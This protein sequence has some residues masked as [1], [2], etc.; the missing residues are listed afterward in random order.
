MS[1]A[2]IVLL[3][4]HLYTPTRRGRGRKGR[5]AGSRRRGSPH[6]LERT[7]QS[8]GVGGYARRGRVLAAARGLAQQD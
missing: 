2:A 6:T 5:G 8:G 3:H 1:P 7:P 4:A